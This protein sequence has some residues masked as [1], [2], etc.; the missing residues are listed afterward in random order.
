MIQVIDQLLESDTSGEQLERYGLRNML[1]SRYVSPHDATPHD[2]FPRDVLRLDFEDRSR[3]KNQIPNSNRSTD[4]QLGLGYSSNN[5]GTISRVLT[6][7]EMNTPDMTMETPT[8]NKQQQQPQQQ[9]PQQQQQQQHKDTKKKKKKQHQDNGN[10]L[11]ADRP[12]HMFRT[13]EPPHRGRALWNHQSKED[14]MKQVEEEIMSMNNRNDVKLNEEANT[15][16]CKLLA[17]HK[18]KVD[19]TPTTSLQLKICN[20]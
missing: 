6:E 3:A 9:Q 11:R 4:I 8:Q 14:E 1:E 16:R 10:K 19:L 15:Y 13:I 5:D 7:N 18:L 17:A 2:N 12:R 20:K